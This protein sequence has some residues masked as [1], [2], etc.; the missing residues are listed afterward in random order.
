MTPAIKR[1]IGVSI[2][3]IFLIGSLIIFSS[4]ILPTSK[5][6]QDLRGERDA[7][8]ILLEEESVKLDT[9]KKLFGEY[10][11]IANLQST[12]SM[13]L[14]TEEDLPGLIN[15]LNGIA[16]T[17]GIVIKTLDIQTLP[18]R[19]ANVDGAIG[20]IGTIN[21]SL[22]VIGSY[23]SIKTYIDALETNIRIIDV[24]SLRLDGG[25]EGGGVLEYEIVIH[26]YYQT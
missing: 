7:L 8:N 21:L 2:S 15:Q 24:Q 16:N 6:V 23:E 25:T 20:P 11:G 3:L 10:G 14:P 5:E 4:M 18:N 1:L 22:D 12:L 19:S 13:A 9:L 26:A 17:T